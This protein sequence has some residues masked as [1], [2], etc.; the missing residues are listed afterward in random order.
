VGFKNYKQLEGRFLSIFV[1]LSLAI[2]VVLH[3][4]YWALLAPSQD[5]VLNAT[6]Q[7]S[8]ISVK[9]EDEKSLPTDKSRTE[10][11]LDQDGS[12]RGLKRSRFA[13][14]S[15]LAIYLCLLGLQP[16]AKKNRESTPL[17][18]AA[19]STKPQLK[20]SASEDFDDLI[21]GPSKKPG[22]EKKLQGLIPD[23]TLMSAHVVSVCML[24]IS[25]LAFWLFNP[26]IQRRR[27]TVR[28]IEEEVAPVLPKG[29]GSYKSK[30]LSAD[31]IKKAKSA[32]ASPVSPPLSSSGKR[33]ADHSGKRQRD[34]EEEAFPADVGVSDESRHPKKKRKRV[35][36]APEE[37]LVQVK[38]VE[39]YLQPLVRFAPSPYGGTRFVASAQQNAHAKSNRRGAC[40]VALAPSWR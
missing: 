17:V 13:C 32:S 2:V 11:K 15:L 24:D 3:H 5:V 26:D 23:R 38:T 21:T 31:D 10:K 12:V 14:S 39:K 22:T 35:S 37:K 16:L 33:D 18:A 34:E 27:P 25:D 8:D 4:A 6:K 9:K 40:F 29:G 30:P 1:P 36:W 20:I 28:L 7:K 19:A